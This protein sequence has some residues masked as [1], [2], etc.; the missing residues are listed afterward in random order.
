MNLIRNYRNWRAYRETVT[1]LGRL[2]NRQLA[3]SRHRPRRDQSRSPARRSNRN[4]ARVDLLPDPDGYG[5]RSP[6]PDRWPLKRRPPHL[7]PR[8]ALFP[9]KV[10]PPFKWQKEFRQNLPPPGNWR[11]RS[12]FTSSRSPTTKTTPAG[13]PPPA[14]VVVSGQLSGLGFLEIQVRPSRK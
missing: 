3:R 11:I 5:Q 8:R 14:G 9:E 6:P 7:L 2:S 13:P 4:F 1:E 10:L 12:A